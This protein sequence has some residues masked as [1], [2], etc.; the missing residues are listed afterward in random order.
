MQSPCSCGR[1]HYAHGL[2]HACYEKRRRREKPELFDRERQRRREDYQAK[3]ADPV[4][5]EL[6]RAKT[7][8]QHARNMADPAWRARQRERSKAKNMTPRGKDYRLKYLYGIPLA[9][10]ERLRARQHNACAICGRAPDGALRVDHDHRTGR[11]RGLLCNK[12]N[13]GLGLLGDDRESLTRAI[14]YLDSSSST[15]AAEK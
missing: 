3:M 12:C 13:I 5:R 15:V 7:R 11:V 10:Y 6:R 8:A 9:E 4:R 14:A 2:C 1:P